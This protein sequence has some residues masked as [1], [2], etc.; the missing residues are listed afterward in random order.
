MLLA[1]LFALSGVASQSGPPDSLRALARTVPDSQF[2]DVV[3]SRSSDVR[4]ALALTLARTTGGDAETRAAEMAI[5]R[6]LATAYAVAWKDSFLVR[7]VDRVAA[8]SLIQRA[9]KIAADSL[10]Q[11]GVK[12]Y[13][14]RG[15]RAAIAVWRQSLVRSRAIDDS[16]SVA[17]TLGNIAAAYARLG[18]LDSASLYLTR[19]LVLA[20]AVGDRRVEANALAERAGVR[21]ARDDLS[22]ARDDYAHA[23]TLRERMG[24]ARGLAADLNNLGLLSIRIGDLVGAR[25]NFEAALKI[26]RRDQRRTSAA[27]NLVN[28]AGLES[29]GGNYRAA[30]LAYREAL[31]VW[32]AN[33]RSADAADAL[34]GLGQLDVRRGDYRVAV[35]ELREA[36]AAY[37]QAGLIDDAVASRQD[38]AAALAATGALQRALDEL[39]GAQRLADSIPSP[40]AVR[41][42]I[43]LARADLAMRLNMPAEAKRRY[44]VALSLYRA[45]GDGEGEAAAQDGHAVLLLGQGELVRARDMLTASLTTHR[46]AGNEREAA[47]TGMSLG[48]LALRQGDTTLG[49]RLLIRAAADLDRLGDPV[50]AAAALGARASVEAATKL[51]VLAESLYVAA[52][53]RVGSRQAPDV[54]WPLHAGLADLRQREGAIDAAMSELRVSIGEIERASSSLAV[55]ERRSA[56]LADKID[57]HIR[58]ALLEQH[59]GRLDSAFALSERVRAREMLDLLRQGRVASPPVASDLVAREQDLRRQISE[60]TLALEA[61][62]NM[63]GSLRGPDATNSGAVL[64]ESLVRAQH[65][66]SDLQLEIRDRAPRHAA[67]LTYESPRL[68]DVARR[69]SAEDVFVEFLVSDTASLVF[70]VTHDTAAVVR[71]GIGRRELSRTI[72]F[73]RGTLRPRGNARLDSLWRAPLTRLHDVLISPIEETGLLAGKT[74]L[75]IVPQTDLHYLPFSALIDRLTRRFLVERYEIVVTPSAAVWLALAARPAVVTAGVLA[76]AP[77]VEALPAS[78]DEVEAVARL[79]DAR[80]LVGKAA[81]EEVFRRE[82]PARRVIHLATYGVLNKHNPLFSFVDLASGGRDDGRLEVGEVFGLT[83]NADLVVLS[84]CQTAIGSGTLSDVPAGDDWVGL[85]RAFLHAGAARVVASLW[86]V[87]DRATA[88]LM[89]RFYRSYAGGVAVSSALATAQRAMIAEKATRHPFLWAAFQL[90]GEP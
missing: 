18:Q 44:A 52:L 8:M 3:R 20:P 41:A 16:A 65:E 15:P 31:A 77:N 1:A 27:T 25:G 81:S 42:G 59:R 56:F 6:R 68:R 7:Q 50:A 21:E 23:I 76:F 70:V 58:L 5:A 40:S 71:L 29:R 36:A 13:E 43:A 90:V 9:A 26:N 53:S 73:V 24:D 19:T 64:R 30:E 17:A 32:R 51:L 66:Y 74:R 89:E 61:T 34:R 28:L 4:E 79:M 62:T 37:S 72:D 60:L 86:A 39:R 14:Q 38:L 55:P 75:M 78:N 48:Q 12:R 22:G 47:L 35:A 10:R 82:A 83:L 84:A 33:Q 80:V 69:L 54:T 85:S 2:V 45:A 46:A 49:R 88:T 11:A 87:D 57:V 63:G 67:L